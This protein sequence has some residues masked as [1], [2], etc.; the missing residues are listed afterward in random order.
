MNIVVLLILLRRFGMP[1]PT[2]TADEEAK[3]KARLARFAPVSKTDPLE[4]DKRKA[5]ALR[6]VHVIIWFSRVMSVIRIKRAWCLIRY[7]CSLFAGLQI[8][9]QLQ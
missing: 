2:T 5:R 9:H 6:W 1:S 7:F 4:E 3:K 8:H